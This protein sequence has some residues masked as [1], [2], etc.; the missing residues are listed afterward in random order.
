MLLIQQVA[1]GSSVVRGSAAVARNLTFN[2]S[3]RGHHVTGAG[4]GSGTPPRRSHRCFTAHEPQ[5]S[6]VQSTYLTIVDF[7]DLFRSFMLHARKDLRDLFD[8]QLATAGGPG[9]GGAAVEM[10]TPSSA[11]V[12]LGS[13]GSGATNTAFFPSFPVNS[14]LLVTHCFVVVSIR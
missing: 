7:I 8:Q 9:G 5:L 13:L 11:G 12:G 1:D 2:F 14:K 6:V 4:A 3:R 10:L